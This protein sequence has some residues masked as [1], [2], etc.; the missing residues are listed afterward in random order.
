MGSASNSATLW[1]Q[2]AMI[3]VDQVDLHGFYLDQQ[4]WENHL[5]TVGTPRGHFARE[6]HPHSVY[7]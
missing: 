1:L 7:C 4:P 6:R 3:M 5:W 2:E